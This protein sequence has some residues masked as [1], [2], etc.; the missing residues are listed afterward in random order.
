M[1]DSSPLAS[2]AAHA[3]TSAQFD[4]FFQHS[5]D[6]LC[7][8]SLDDG[9]FKKVNPSWTRVLGW[10]EEELLSR[11]VHEF[12]HP[13]DRERTLAARAQLAEGVPVRWLENRYLCKDGSARWLSWQS[14][15]DPERHV[16]FGI[17]RDVTE[18]REAERERLV[19]GKLESTGILAGGMAHDYNN[20]LA[21]LRLNLDMVEFSGP[22]T[23][24]QRHLLNQAK[25][26]IDAAATLTRQLIAFADGDVS[27]MR[28]LDLRPLVRQAI[29]LTLHDAPVRQVCEWAPDLATVRGN[30]TQLAQVFR[31]LLL[32]ARE[33]TP[34]GGSIAVRAE[35]ATLEK[36]PATDLRPGHYVRIRISDTGAGIPHE[37][38]PKIFDPYFSTKERG[39]QKG[40]GLSLTLCR[41]ILH[42]LG[43][44]LTVESKPGQ[45]TTVT[46]YLPAMPAN[47][48]AP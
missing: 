19:V 7:F 17:A 35:N 45:G 47:G 20:L 23:L 12:M 15:T 40:M 30:E 43:G 4:H 48:P 34:A 44:A 39:Q 5:L 29:E 2:D 27:G 9:Y 10:S 1:P 46:C 18:R 22:V 38:L 41:V 31:G 24:T 8:A 16:V 28:T 6:L 33:A 13:E 32:N 14:I 36:T 42:R 3:I 37:V 25:A 26:T 11:P 21:A